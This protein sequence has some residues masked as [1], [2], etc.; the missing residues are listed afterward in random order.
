MTRLHGQL[1]VQKICMCSYPHAGDA[2]AGKIA[3]KN[4]LAA[5]YI[6]Q[7]CHIACTRVATRDFHCTLVMRHF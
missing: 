4:H 5:K 6:V 2:T 3:G 7:A 1:P